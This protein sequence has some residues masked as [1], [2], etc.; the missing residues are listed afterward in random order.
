MV[1]CYYFVMEQALN[2]KNY[3]REYAEFSLHVPEK[4]SFPSISSINGVPEL[5]II[6]PFSGQ[7]ENTKRNL[8]SMN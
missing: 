4:F 1:I 6:L 5:K 7:M 3:M 8:H 2:M